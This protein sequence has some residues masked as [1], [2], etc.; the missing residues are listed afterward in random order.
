ML[1]EQLAAGSADAD[2]V[3][4]EIV[5]LALR[6]NLVSA[7]TSFISVDALSSVPP[8]VRPVPRVEQATNALPR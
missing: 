7:M 3:R 4:R 2:G 1:S 5:E 8:A 6:H